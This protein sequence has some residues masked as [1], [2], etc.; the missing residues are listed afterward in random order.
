MPFEKLSSCNKKFDN[1]E[2]E[3]RS[4]VDFIKV[5]IE[6]AEFEFLKGALST[7]S[8]SKPVII[9]ELLRKWMLPFGS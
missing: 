9:S 4:Q 3:I 1:L 5:D 6:G 8:D 2:K 7:I